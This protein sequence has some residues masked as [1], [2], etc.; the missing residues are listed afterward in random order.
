MII[1]QADCLLHDKCNSVPI[2]PGLCRAACGGVDGDQAGAA[3]E[4]CAVDC[5]VLGQADLRQA[6]AVLEGVR[7]DGGAGVR[8]VHHTHDGV[9]LKCAFLNGLD[10]GGKRKCRRTEDRC[11]HRFYGEVL[12]GHG[13]RNSR[14][15]A[16]E[17]K[18]GSGRIC[19][20]KCFLFWNA[21]EDF[22]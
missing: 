17:D 5:A 4:G 7:A 1:L 6:C 14:V 22:L 16:V 18:V 21:M 9:A 11:P 10:R 2:R 13:G 8:D 15:P 20:A 3:G 19:G 12:C